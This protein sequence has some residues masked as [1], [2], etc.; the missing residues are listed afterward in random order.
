MKLLVFC[1]AVLFGATA[2]GGLPDGAVKDGRSPLG[3][4]LVENIRDRDNPT[5][6]SIAH[7]DNPSAFRRIYTYPRYADL[8]FAADE[9]YLVIDDR[10]GSG[11]SE[12]II[13]KQI[14]KPPFYVKPRKIDDA[15]WKLFWSLHGKPKRV[16]YDHQRTY[17]CEWLD[18][19]H[20]VVGLQGDHFFPDPGTQK[21]ALGGGWHCVYDIARDKAYTSEYTDSKNVGA[22]FEILD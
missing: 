22:K 14:A 17:F 21:W 16:S 4:Y 7:R 18:S 10:C 19:T 15:C 1:L 12:C 3:T 5:D 6:I 9:K 11:A 8:Y 2:F 13:L 20:F